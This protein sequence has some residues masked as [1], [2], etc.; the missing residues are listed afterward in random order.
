MKP[1]ETTVNI[2]DQQESHPLNREALQRATAL[3]TAKAVTGERPV[4]IDL[5]LVEKPSMAELNMAHLNHEGPTDII[6]FE[7]STPELFHGELV[8]CPAVAQDHAKDFGNSLGEE[9][10]RYIIHGVLHLLG[11]ND[12]EPVDREKMKSEEDRLVD[13]LRGEM[14]LTS[15]THE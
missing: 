4:Q 15:L 7:Y 5:V 9:L 14:D 6:T 13:W 8:I 1:G 10:G 3:I 11:H 12:H 2:T